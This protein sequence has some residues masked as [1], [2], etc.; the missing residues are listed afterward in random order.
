MSNYES[1]R[2]GEWYF[3]RKSDRRNQDAFRRDNRG[4][5]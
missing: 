3:N 5:V 2:K 1:K 4:L